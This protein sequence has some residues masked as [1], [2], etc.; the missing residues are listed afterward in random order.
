MT[1]PNYTHMAF[2]LD[3]SGSMQSIKSD[4]EGG[5]D[6]FIAE[7]KTQP[8][9]CTVTLADFS[10]YRGIFGVHQPAPGVRGVAMNTLPHGG[11]NLDYRVRYTG[12]DIHEVEPLVVSP[13]GGTA[14]LDSIARLV[15]ETGEYLSAM[16]Q[17]QRPGLVIVGIM[18]DG[19]ENASR[20]WTRDAIKALIEQQESQYSWV[21]HY[22][23]ANQDAIEEGAKMGV[24]ADSSLTYDAGNAVGAMATY[25]ASVSTMRGAVAGGAG[26][27]AARSS[28]AY[29]D[30]QRKAAGSKRG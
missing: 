5:F 11:G 21:F 18:T 16:P 15:Q 4:V 9:R 28:A 26:V 29:T 2:L 1:N 25:G 17:D 23:G 8:G 22:L 19:L 24:R 10:D 30:E 14:L 13:R 3:S 27:E 6:A 12:K 7:Q 20:E